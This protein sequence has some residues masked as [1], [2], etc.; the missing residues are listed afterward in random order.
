M[1]K[2]KDSLLQFFQYHNPKGTL[3]KFLDKLGINGK[4]LIPF[5]MSLSHHERNQL[6][7]SFLNSETSWSLETMLLIRGLRIARVPF[8]IPRRIA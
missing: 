3:P 8:S 1:L 7:H 2:T 4:L 6:V 5:T